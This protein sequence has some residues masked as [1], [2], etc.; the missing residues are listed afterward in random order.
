MLLCCTISF[1]LASCVAP[2]LDQKEAEALSLEGW[3]REEIALPPQFAP[4]LPAGEEI[5]LFAPGMFDADAE[6]FWSYVFLM[7]VREESMSEERILEVFELYYDGLILAVAEDRK[8]DV[9]DDPAQVQMKSL[10]QG[11]FEMEIDL[12]DAFV[13]MEP[14]HL[15]LIVEVAPMDLG[16]TLLR[17]RATPMEKEHK[18]WLQLNHALRSLKFDS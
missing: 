8:E 18:V 1:L 2:Q 3:Y 14:L 16:G 10:G 11:V 5:L 9:G 4:D 13:T 12:V 15:N 7:Q 17:V 6:D